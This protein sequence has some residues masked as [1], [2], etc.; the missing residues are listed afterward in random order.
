MIVLAIAL[1][2]VGYFSWQSR[3]QTV[4]QLTQFAN[5]RDWNALGKALDRIEIS[6]NPNLRDVDLYFKGILYSNSY[7]A[8]DPERFLAQISPDSD[9]FESA[10]EVRFRIIQNRETRNLAR[11]LLTHSTARV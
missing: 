10:Q 3:S 8:P 9:L 7:P 11:P 4:A 5:D 1:T 2:T 6:H